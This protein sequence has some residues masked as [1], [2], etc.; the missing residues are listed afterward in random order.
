MCYTYGERTLYF[1]LQPK[2]PGD[3]RRATGDG[4]CKIIIVVVLRYTP[5]AY[6]GVIAA[7]NAANTCRPL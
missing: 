7:L 6:V 1:K 4:Y 3:G 2:E 5:A